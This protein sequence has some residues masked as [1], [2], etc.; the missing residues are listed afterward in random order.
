MGAFRDSWGLTRT[1]FQLIREDPALLALPA[2]AGGALL[3]LVLLF[4]LP[5]VGW[6]LTDPAS[7]SA[8][9]QSSGGRWAFVG[10]YVGLYFL[11]VFVGNFFFA[12][13][14]GAAT[15]KLEGGH[16]SVGDGIRF[17]RAHLGRI[18]IWSLIAA[19]VGLLIRLIASRFQGIVGVVIGVAAGVGWGIATY[20][21]LPVIL[22][23]RQG[24]WGR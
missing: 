19:S 4:T 18:V 12:A 11:L 7:A 9:A 14:I 15:L 16:P 17:A 22:Y 8:F 21:A 10:L 5:F 2:I 20:F 3:G 23:E 24:P 13:L 1:S 6:F